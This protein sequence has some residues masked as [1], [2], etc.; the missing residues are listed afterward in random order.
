[1][2]IRRDSGTPAAWLAGQAHAGPGLRRARRA[3][4]GDLRPR[5]RGRGHRR[6]QR[7][8]PPGILVRQPYEDADIGQYKAIALA[9][10][11]NQIHADDRVTALP[12]DIIIT[13]LTDEM[14]AAQFDLV[15]DA[16]AN[17]AVSIAPGKHC[18]ARQPRWHGHRS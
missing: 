13:V 12:Q 5:R 17:A 10:R 18:R 8:R 9:D 15:I 1:M 14:Q 6:R 3:C 4:G 11:L 7:H 16:T 2:T